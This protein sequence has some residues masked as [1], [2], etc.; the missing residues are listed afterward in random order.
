MAL[1]MVTKKQK[2]LSQNYDGSVTEGGITSM[3]VTVVL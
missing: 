2:N 3:S 1:V